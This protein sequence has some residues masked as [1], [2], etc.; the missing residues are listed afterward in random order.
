MKHGI[1]FLFIAAALAACVSCEREALPVQDGEW[2]TIH[3]RFPGELTRGA[4]ITETGISW[5]WN[6]GDVLTISGTTTETYTIKEGFTPKQADFTGKI[7]YGN[8]FT[9]AYPSLEEVNWAT[10]TQKGN[11][12][13]AHL[14]Y[15]AA[16]EGVDDYN[17]FVFSPSWAQNH[18][19]TLRQTGALKFAFKFPEALTDIS[20]IVLSA[21]SAIFYAGNG[22]ALTDK[23]TLN[24]E[25]VAALAAGEEL[26]GWLTTSWNETVVPA[27][28]TLTV[29]V[30]ATEKEYAK[31]LTF[32]TDSPLKSGKV[33]TLSLAASAWPSDVPPP[34]HYEGEGTQA[35]PW[36]ITTAQQMEYIKEDIVAGETRYFRLGADIDMT[37]VEWESLNAVSPFDKGIDFD[38]AGYKISNLSCGSDAYP[39]LFGVLYGKCYDLTIENATIVADTNTGAGIL[40]GY[41][42]TTDKPGEASNVSVQGTVEG[43]STVGGLFGSSKEGTITDCSVQATVHT[44]GGNAGGVVGIAGGNVTITACSFEGSVTAD[45]SCVGGVVGTSSGYTVISDCWTAGTVLS[46]TQIAGGIVGDLRTE[47][48]AVYRCFSGS[49]VTAQFYAGGIVGRANLNQKGSVANNTAADPKNHIEKCIAWNEK[50]ESNAT[51]EGEHYSNGGIIGSTALKNYLVDC[52]RKADLQ[53]INCVGNVTAGG[54]ELFDQENANPETPMVRGTGTYNCAYNGKAASLGA[55]ITSLAQSLGWSADIWDF[56][57]NVPGHKEGRTWDHEDGNPTV[58]GQLSDFDENTIYTE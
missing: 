1:K 34:V 17:S 48:S 39:G 11:G 9:I 50:I 26:V 54:Y 38:G 35:S 10:Q 36:I 14:R 27:G 33:N 4:E 51:D 47:N 20:S 58:D 22:D 57:G 7:V 45:A 42:G 52:F 43:I 41:C 55:S 31:E 13:V 25:D 12:D 53:L 30:K 3:A 40:G 49:A 32:A 6:A 56:S 23:L 37:G 46:V 24:F 2:I 28:T 44:T 15:V 29:T 16:L 8:S 21:P 18:G 5:T 19:G